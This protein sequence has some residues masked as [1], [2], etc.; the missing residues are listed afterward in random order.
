MSSWS[1]GLRR[2][3]GDSR[4]KLEDIPCVRTLGGGWVPPSS[5]VFFPRQR[6]E[7]EFPE[8]LQVPITALPEVDGL[9]PLLETA[10]VRSF[11]WRQLIP[12]FVIP[13]LTDPEVDD[14]TRRA[15][16]VAL[17]GYYDTE[18]TGDPRMRL[19]IA[20]VL[21]PA[22]NQS[23]S[24]R[25]LRPA[26]SLY[27]SRDWLGHDRL[28]RIYG[29]FNEIEF[30]AVDP[31]EDQEQR[32]ADRAF[33]EW[34]GVTPHPRIDVRRAEQRDQ[35]PIGNL[36]R[37][38]HRSYGKFWTEWETEVVQGSAACEQGHTT[39]QQLKSSFALDRFPEL[40][41]TNDPDRL[42]LLWKELCV[43][44]SRYAP[45]LTSQIQCHHGWHSSAETVRTVPSLLQHMLRRCAWVPCVRHRQR[46]VIPPDHAWRITADTPP[47]IIERVAVLDRALDVPGSAQIIAALDVVDA[48]RPAPTNL[49]FLLRDLENDFVEGDAEDGRSVQLAARWAMRTLND[50]LDSG[51]LQ[52]R[53]PL[54]ARL[55]GRHVFSDK[56][57]VATDP[58]LAETW[59]PVF[60]IL[61]A[62]RDLRRLHD[63]LQL[64]ILDEEVK[65]SPDPRG[66]RADR[67]LAVEAQINEAKP[68]L[69][70]VAIDQV[71]SRQ[72]D[73]LRGLARL[74]VSVCDELILRYELDGETRERD[75]A[76]SYIAE[77]IEHEGIIRRRIG[78]AHLELD[79]ESQAPHWYALGPQLAQFLGVPTQGDA[80]AL[81]L[82][83]TKSDR[84]QYLAARRIP[85]AAVEEARLEFA[86]TPS[87]E[88]IE[89]LLHLGE[90]Q[91]SAEEATVPS[92][93]ETS[94]ELR[95]AGGESDESESTES[96]V[97]LPEL[98]HDAVSMTD[99]AEPDEREGEDAGRRRRPPGLGPPGPV[100]HERQQR[101]QLR[102][103]RRGEEAVYE[104][105]RRRLLALRRDPALVVWRS[106]ERELAPYDIES[107][108]E[109]GQQIYIEVKSTTSDDP[110]DPFEISEAELILALQ[111]RS[112]YYIYRVTDAHTASPSITRFRDPIHRLHHNTAR[113]RLSGARLTFLPDK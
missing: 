51:I 24:T 21:L 41:A 91:V 111:K 104:A 52:E 36:Y 106:R 57:L 85:F 49:A 11:E 27:F 8:G 103:G 43:G 23:G 93:A 89:D 50:V 38:P 18:R 48:A 46:S 81:L 17:R 14:Q 82:A 47:R 2:K 3:A 60:P 102:I 96:Q 69:A 42:T 101:V 6:E 16:F 113:L 45:A 72:G 40:A 112:R 107:L 1:S 74:E 108:D 22:A 97:E 67:R 37:H 58:L 29:P 61:D 80:F 100:D 76:V 70:A 87:D 75:E 59:E 33:Y 88:V 73:I 65:T 39:A 32:Q 63:A 66:P 5:K 110:Y 55:D 71:P 26:G 20:Q 10:G 12:E 95:G 9:R 44:W 83:A 13:L 7:V 25:S 79:P 86:Q 99:G 35:Y 98:D 68:Y 109:D 77:R 31:S 78:T 28:E 92:E 90:E 15:A 4:P 84:E 19:Q 62:D 53:V 54:L 105:E 64:R 94:R 30:L 34:V 56:P